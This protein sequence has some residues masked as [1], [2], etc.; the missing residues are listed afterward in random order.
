[1]E[2]YELE[3]FLANTMDKELN[4]ELEDNSEVQVA[5]WL[6]G[7]AQLYRAGKIAELNHE[8]AL[9]NLKKNTQ[10]KACVSVG[11]DPKEDEVF[12]FCL[13]ISLKTGKVAL[14]V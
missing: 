4:V 1:M 5:A 8:V 13:L 10:S 7:F 3:E 14:Y 11:D 12:I 6:L 9:K 2:Q